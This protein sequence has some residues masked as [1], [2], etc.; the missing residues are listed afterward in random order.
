MDRGAGI[1]L[2]SPKVQSA[3]R[4]SGRTALAVGLG[5]WTASRFCNQTSPTHREKRTKSFCV[6]YSRQAGSDEDSKKS[7]YLHHRAYLF[8]DKVAFAVSS[9]GLGIKFV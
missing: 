9:S 3:I 4:G 1:G 8:L 7:E 2:D 6:L 5:H